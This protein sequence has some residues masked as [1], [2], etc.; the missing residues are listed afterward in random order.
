[1]E[2]HVIYT[3]IQFTLTVL[4]CGVI[5]PNRYPGKYWL[6]GVWTLGVDAPVVIILLKKRIL[7]GSFY[8]VLLYEFVQKLNYENWKLEI[9]NTRNLKLKEKQNLEML[10]MVHMTW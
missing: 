10:I 7:I 9:E 4:P 6:G 2:L 3:S 8:F 5:S 1:M